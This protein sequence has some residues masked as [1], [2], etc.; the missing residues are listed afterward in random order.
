M[1]GKN[2]SL[3]KR[4]NILLMLA[5]MSVFVFS[6]FFGINVVDAA[7]V[8]LTNPTENITPDDSL[9]SATVYKVTLDDESEIT[10]SSGYLSASSY[11]SIYVYSDSSC[12]NKVD[13]F[14]LGDDWSNQMKLLTLSANTYYFKIVRNGMSAPKVK[15][16]W[17]KADKNRTFETAEEVTIP[18]GT[19]KH[20]DLGKN[21]EFWW[22]LNVPTTGKYTF[23]NNT[24]MSLWVM[25]GKESDTGKSIFEPA[26][27]SL[28]GKETH[29]L[30]PGVY[31]IMG[32]IGS[33][34]TIDFTVVNENYNEL[35]AID[36]DA[37]VLMGA[38]SSCTYTLKLTPAVSDSTITTKVEGNISLGVKQVDKSTY[39]F[40][41][42]TYH[43]GKVN[44]VFKTN[45]GLSKTVEVAVGPVAASVKSEGTH[46]STTLKMQTNA[47]DKPQY[48]VYQLEGN[49]YKKVGSTST[50]SCTIKN[51]KPNSEYTFKV[52]AYDG[53]IPGGETIH[54]AITASN[55]KVAGI[56]ASCTGCKFYKGKKDTWEYDKFRGWYKVIHPAHSY[57][58]I[59]VKYKKP[60]GASYVIV[61]GSNVKS[62]GKISIY[63]RGRVKAGKKTGVTFRTVRKSADSIAYGPVTTKKVK[64]KG[65]K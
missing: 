15:L 6:G 16:S 36:G 3:I 33:S 12:L 30:T 21:G 40:E 28:N 60:S 55:K 8:E 29:Y 9:D 45:D 46:N 65:A 47:G 63:Y 10:A 20:F 34:G 53:D 42:S 18:E 23:K 25:P 58:T 48:V 19:E 41:S 62:G 27:G 54:K 61:N 26:T 13:N 57:A 49:D 14:D 59:K 35:T 51:L 39:V 2:L 24:T 50:D 56:K 31:T 5:V 7:T 17:M 32:R 22:Y 52:V 1:V 38:M 11:A 43:T 64:L 4:V 44:V 37:K